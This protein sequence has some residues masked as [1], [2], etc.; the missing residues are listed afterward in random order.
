M[1]AGSFFS[2]EEYKS[3]EINQDYILRSVTHFVKNQ[4]Y[5][6]EFEANPIDH[7]IRPL[8]K[9]K[10]P[11][12]EGTHSAF[13]VGPPG[14]EIWT[15]SLG[16]IKVKFHWDNSDMR[17]ENSSCWLRVSQ[18]SADT[19]WG[20]LFIPRVGQEVLVSYV[21]GDPDKPVVTGC[22][23]NSERDRP[24]DLPAKQT[25]SVIR[26]K[27]F[28]KSTREDTD[29]SYATDMSNFTEAPGGLSSSPTDFLNF[30]VTDNNDGRGIG[31]EIRFED[32]M[33]EEE[34]YQHAHKD[35]KIDVENNLTTTIF[36]GSEIHKIE[37]GSRTVKVLKG[38]EEH[39]VKKDRVVTVEGEEVR[40]N[41]NNFTQNIDGDYECNVK[42]DYTLNVE[43]DL[44]IRVKGNVLIEA[45]GSIKTITQKE[46]SQEAEKTFSIK[47]KD[48]FSVESTKSSKLKALSLELEAD[49]SSKLKGGTSVEIN[50]AANVSV[51]SPQIA[52]G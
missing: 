12:V 28:T 34:F 4:E 45:E 9:T 49:T 19:G 44:L 51:S 7:P 21:D 24:V 36:K 8:K 29:K 30:I 35:M 1:E 42:G 5:K 13:V 11:K 25:Q 3:T 31:N 15:D 52:L 46:L 26:S 37:K 6:N 2:L 22:V 16:R 10:L 39:F 32:K 23:Y 50:G 47:S 43:G 38:G 48:R 20:H 27:P 18:T 14:E 41:S 40:N 33:N 17:N